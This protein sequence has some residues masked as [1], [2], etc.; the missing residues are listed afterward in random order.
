MRILYVDIDTLRPDHLGCYGYHRDTSPNIDKLAAEGVRF[1]NCYVSDAPCLPSRA[2]LYSGRFG[3]RNGAIN[4]GGM[5]ADYT[6]DPDDRQFRMIADHLTWQIRHAGY[7]PVSVSPFGERH[8]SFWFYNGFREMYNTGKGGIERADEITPVALD[9]LERGG[10]Q[11][12]WYLHVNLWDPHTPYQVPKEFGNPFEDSPPPDWM[13]EEIRKKTWD[14][15]GPGNAQEPGGAYLGSAPYNDYPRMPPALDSPETYKKWIDGYDTGIRYADHHI[16][17]IVNKLRELGIYD[18]TM[19]IV[20]SDHGENQGELA[21][22]GD[23]QTADQITN[24]VPMIIRDPRGIGGQGRVDTALHYQ[25]DVFATMVEGI[26]GH[27][28]EGWDARSFFG[29]FKEEKEQGRDHLVISNCAWACQRSVR[30]GDHLM[31]RSYHTGFKNYADKMLFDVKND[32]HELVDLV[33]EKPELVKE[34]ETKLEE[35]TAAGIA[36]NPR[37]EDPMQTVL[38]EGGPFHARY[39]SEDY[40]IYVERLKATGREKFAQELEQRKRKHEEEYG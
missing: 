14:T 17:L 3:I 26:G 11:D 6:I 31:I 1:D 22:Y 5:A 32:P 20:S 25:F 2:A 19:I 16:G 39:G 23:H 7:Y 29:A 35:W 21:V 15:Y 9:W 40:K 28:P 18:D 34:A 27:L 13:T 38:K 33:G 8:S 10:K 12:N 30:W 36:G 4:H 37:N 24:R